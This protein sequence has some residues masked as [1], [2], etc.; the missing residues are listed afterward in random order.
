MVYFCSKYLN[1]LYKKK[2]RK[3]YEIN[4]LQVEILEHS[5]RAEVLSGRG[6]YKGYLDGF[7]LIKIM[8]FRC[9]TLCTPSPPLPEFRSLPR[10]WF[11]AESQIK[12]SRQRRL[13]NRLLCREPDKKLS[14]QKKT[15]AKDFFTK[16]QLAG[17]RQRI[18]LPSAIF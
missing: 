7:L 5:G 11:C 18:S 3:A 14:A 4:L 16:S 13:C 2:W 1:S 15:L 12:N 6:A 8:H 9:L 10:V 17:S